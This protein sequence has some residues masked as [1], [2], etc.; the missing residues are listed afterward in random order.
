MS[1]AAI[2]A[3][4]HT[5]CEVP[6]IYNDLAEADALLAAARRSR[7]T[8]MLAENCCYWRFIQTWKTLVADG[9][10]GRVTYAEGE[11]VH[12]VPELMTDPDGTL[13][14]RASL[15]PL[16][17][18]T[19]EL[20]PLLEIMNDR[21]TSVVAMDTG[22]Q[23]EPAWPAPDQAV[24]LFRTG[25]GRVIKIL[26]SFSNARRPP[27]HYYS[28]YGTAGCLETSRQGAKIL[29]NFDDQP[30]AAGPIEMP[31]EYGP[32]TGL[33]PAAGHGG[34]DAAMVYDFV[35]CLMSDRPSPIDAVRALEFSVPGLCARESAR[36]GS[37]PVGVPDYRLA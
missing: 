31:L 16:Q 4:L 19:H 24:G 6:A 22:P 30:D 36:Q 5:I 14:W 20:G 2:D 26:C 35:D 10:I 32:D 15:Y 7:A 8:Y 25:A 3:G 34:A 12:D 18:L 27:H 29:A 33:D 28:I 23:R 11:Y 1:V 21:V 13:T 37:R 17:Y 9:R